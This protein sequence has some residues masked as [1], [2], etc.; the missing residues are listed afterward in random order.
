[1]FLEERVR[2]SPQLT[3]AARWEEVRRTK[4]LERRVLVCVVRVCAPLRG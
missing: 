2:C 4:P 1:M 3:G